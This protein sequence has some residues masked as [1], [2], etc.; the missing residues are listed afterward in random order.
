MLPLGDA[1]LV[2][3]PLDGEEL[4][5]RRHDP[6][7]HQRQQQRPRPDDQQA[8]QRQ[9]ALA[10]PASGVGADTAGT[11]AGPYAWAA[12]KSRRSRIITGNLPMRPRSP[13]FIQM[14]KALPTM[15]SPGTKPQ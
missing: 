8:D 6:H 13:K 11:A 15:F 14:K 5:D 3:A 2:T 10:T 1:T 12:C 9:A 7:R 4:E